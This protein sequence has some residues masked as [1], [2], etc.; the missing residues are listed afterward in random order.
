MVILGADLHK[1]WHTVV[2]VS[3]TGRKLGEKTIPATRTGTSSSPLGSAVPGA[4][5]GPRGLPAP[6]AAPGGR[7]AALGRGG[8]AGPAQAHGRC[9]RSVPRAGKS[10]RID[11]SRSPRRRCA[12]RPSGRHTRRPRARAAP[13]RRSSRGPRGRAHPAH[14]AAPLAPAGPGD[15]RAGPRSLDRDAGARSA[16]GRLVGRPEPRPD[17][18]ATSSAGCAASRP[19]P[20]ARARDRGPRRRL[21]PTLL[22]PARLRPAH[23]GQDRGR[24]GRDE[25][26]PLQ[27]GVREAQRLGAGP[28]WSGNVT[29][30]A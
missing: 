15:R 20:L 8:R 17:W 7:P 16:R 23:R 28:V 3:E 1:R 11:A 26:L 19:H 25:P 22:A 14:P 18:P 24:G 6:V 30:S 9:R 21:A 29:G 2:A 5:L 12:S 27:G 10:D 13:A 4:P